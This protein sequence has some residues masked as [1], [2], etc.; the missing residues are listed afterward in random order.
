MA[1]TLLAAVTCSVMLTL[2]G[3]TATLTLTAV[4][5]VPSL[6]ALLMCSRGFTALQRSRFAAL[7]GVDL[8]RARRTWAGEPTW[9]G[10]LHAEARDHSTRRQLLYHAVACLINPLGA[11]VVA[12]LWVNGFI[13]A[14]VVAHRVGGRAALWGLDLHDPLTVSVATIAGGGTAFD[15][16]VVSQLLVRHGDGSRCPAAC[17]PEVR[18]AFRRTRFREVLSS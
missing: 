2:L 3:L 12:G 16:E 15:P 13:M 7:Q 1:G 4:L 14:T 6:Y 5:A 17:W 9:L 8:P 18:R 11:L 10:R